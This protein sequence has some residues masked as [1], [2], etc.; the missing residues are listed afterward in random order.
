MV[1]CDIGTAYYDNWTINCKKKN[2]VPP[3]V[4]KIRSK[5]MLILPNVIMELSN[6]RIKNRV[7]LNVTKIESDAM[8]VLLNVTMEPSNLRKNKGTIICDWRTVKFDIG[9]TQ[10]DNGT[11]KFEKQIKEPLNVTK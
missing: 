4:T 3:N 2:R 5:V 1:R 11:I 6:L 7:P 8:L 9:T 10:Y